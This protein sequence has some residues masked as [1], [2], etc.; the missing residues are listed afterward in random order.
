MALLLGTLVGLGVGVGLLTGS[1][2]RTYDDAMQLAT[3]AHV[4]ANLK[5]A[6]RYYAIAFEKADSVGNGTRAIVAGDAVADLTV[7]RG[8]LARAQ[9]LYEYLLAT[10]PAHVHHM[11]LRFKTEN[12]LAVIHYRQG[13]YAEAQRILEEAAATWRQYPYSPFYPLEVHFLLLRHLAKVYQ[14]KGWSVSADATTQW[15][16]EIVRWLE[17]S[18]SAVRPPTGE[19]LLEYAALL[20]TADHPDEAAELETWGHAIIA[21]YEETIAKYGPSGFRRCE[22]VSRYGVRLPDTCYLEIP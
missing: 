15:V 21:R 4:R 10:Y 20:R 11:P 16:T 8:D 2:P 7:A 17:T 13:R 12:N 18:R 5:A 9:A 22:P 19:V 14:A 1:G 6:E 3:Q